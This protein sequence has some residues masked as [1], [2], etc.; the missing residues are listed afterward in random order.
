MCGFEAYYRDWLSQTN[1]RR[2]CAAHAHALRYVVKGSGA[3][4]VRVVSCLSSVH[5]LRCELKGYFRGQTSS[6][7]VRI[8][9]E[10]AY[11]DMVRPSHENIS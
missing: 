3:R 1:L 5:Q 8:Y 10:I 11:V 7:Y 4:H 6:Y 2:V 9:N